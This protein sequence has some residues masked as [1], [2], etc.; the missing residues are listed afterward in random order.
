MTHFSD[1]AGNI[2]ASDLSDYQSGFRRCVADVDRYA[3]MADSSLSASDRRLISQLSSQLWRSRTAE[4]AI[5]TTDS[6]PS[7]A[8]ARHKDSRTQPKASEGTNVA[9]PP[10]ADASALPCLRTQDARLQSGSPRSRKEA[11]SDN[12]RPTDQETDSAAHSCANITH[13]WRPW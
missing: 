8:K 7:R 3:L 1:F 4:G 12:R 10:A 9:E 6:G 13:M 2:A 5:S 11:A